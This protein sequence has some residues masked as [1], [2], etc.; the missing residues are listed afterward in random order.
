[1]SST[2]EGAP[3]QVE[4]VDVTIARSARALMAWHRIPVESLAAAVHTSKSTVERR[5]KLGGWTA[6][7]AAAVAWAFSLPVEQLYSGAVDI[8]GSR[9]IG[10]PS[11]PGG[12]PTVSKV[13]PKPHLTAVISA[14]R[15]TFVSHD[16][17]LL[18]VVGS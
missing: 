5:L 2:Q 4:P 8:A 14:V 11:G 1:M 10:P 15:P 9:W 17:P 16:R 12:Q 7:E 6:R 18:R 13:V 3:A